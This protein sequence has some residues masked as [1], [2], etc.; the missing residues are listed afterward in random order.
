MK[1]KKRKKEKKDC[2]VLAATDFTTDFTTNLVSV[3]M[4]RFANC[5]QIDYLH[6][7]FV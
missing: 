6:V 4:L 3:Y 1:G 2:D 7:K 5:A